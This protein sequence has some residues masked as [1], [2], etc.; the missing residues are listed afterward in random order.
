[1]LRGEPAKGIV[2]YR[3]KDGTVLWSNNV[4]RG[5]PYMLHGD[6]IITDRYAYSLLTGEQETRVDPLTGEEKP[7]AFKRNYGCNYALASEHLLS[8]RSAAAGFYDLMRDGGTGNFGGFKSGCTSN[9]VVANGVLNAPDYTRT[10][11]CSYQNQTSLALVHMPEVEIWT[12]YFDERKDVD[13]ASS[14]SATA[15][16]DLEGNLTYVNSSFLNLW[17]YDDDTEVVGKP[18][19]ELWQMKEKALQIA[20]ALRDKGSWI[21]ELVAVKKDGSTLNVHL[22]ANMVT[23]ETG[24][25]VSMMVSFVDITN[26]A[27]ALSDLE[28]NLTYV[29]NS[30]LN[31][32]GYDDDTEALGTRFVE[33]W[34]IE[35]KAW[36][37]VEALRSNRRTW[38]GELVALRKD[39]STLD[40]YLSASMVTDEASKPVS[41]MVSFV[42]ITEQ[43]KVEE[44]VNEF[45]SGLR[46]IHNFNQLITGDLPIRA[47][48]INL[49]ASGDRRADNGMLWL[50]YP[51][52][53]GPSPDIPVSI[54]PE[55][56]LFNINPDFQTDLDNRKISAELQ[57][58]FQNKGFSLTQSAMVS[59]EK[60]DSKWLITRDDKNRYIVRKEKDKNIDHEDYDKLN[61]YREDYKRFTHHSSR[62]QVGEGSKPAP[63]WV[64]ASGL[65]GLSSVNITLSGNSS[66]NAQTEDM[67]LI[68]ALIQERPYTV[69]LYFAEP[70]EINPGQR[71][72]DISIQG[73]EVLENFDIVRETG[74]PNRPIVKEFN[75]ILVKDNLVVDFTPSNN[76]KTNILLICGI[77]VLAEGW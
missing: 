59:I 45:K 61:I 56:L 6:T 74:G 36:G 31:L 69:R 65:K 77:E 51:R 58:E 43:K 35:E 44:K 11:S 68:A 18:F 22:S 9:L 75:G 70:D 48:G 10:C 71:V 47:V 54:N 2:A 49:G 57:Q 34:Q 23:D 24:K 38:M 60:K 26:N 20:K 46:D 27:I 12:T 64:V 32:W 63:T 39:G 13:I 29:N 62:I 67:E 17:G 21:G 55:K 72:F 3:G 52:V 53:G 1:M 5:G 40:I 76:D 14:G 8:F 66:T 30:F 41:M 42:D 25:P 37:V 15:F 33:L 73:Q 7:W 19:V 16:A 28:G 50:E 4:S